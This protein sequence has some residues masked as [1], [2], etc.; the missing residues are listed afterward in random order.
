[1]VVVFVEVVASL[2]LGTEATVVG[3]TGVVAG[4]SVAAAAVT[5]AET[6]VGGATSPLSAD[7]SDEEPPQAV[8]TTVS[9]TRSARVRT[10]LKR[11]RLQPDATIMFQSVSS[12]DR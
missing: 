6:S 11:I 3:A 9:E 4:G 10:P 5:D 1:V 8:A 7:S 12:A 2:V